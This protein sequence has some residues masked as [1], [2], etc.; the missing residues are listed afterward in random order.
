MENIFTHEIL[1]FPF[2]IFHSP[3]SILHSPF[4]IPFKFFLKKSIMQSGKVLL[5][6]LAGVAAGAFLGILFAPKKGSKTRRKIMNKGSDYADGLKD[7]FD[8]FLGTVSK[9]VETAQK[10]AESMA[11][12]GKAKYEEAKKDLKNAVV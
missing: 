1:R 2:S 3:F 7:K 11:A 12:N 10:E 4:S 6:A 9:K 8:D 5:G